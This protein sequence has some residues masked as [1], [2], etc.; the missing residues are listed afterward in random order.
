M[1]DLFN[2]RFVTAPQV[3]EQLMALSK[4]NGVKVGFMVEKALREYIAK[5]EKRLSK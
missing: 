3:R 1:S 4:L 5:E 2:A